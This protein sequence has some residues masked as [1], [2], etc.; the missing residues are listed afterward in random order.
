MKR[1]NLLLFIFIIIFC[2]S[3]FAQEIKDKTKYYVNDIENFNNYSSNGWS[4]LED[5]QLKVIAKAL[6]IKTD[7]AEKI[8]TSTS[9]YNH[10][11]NKKNTAIF[12]NINTGIKSFSKV[13]LFI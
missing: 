13:L 8:I 2:N 11:K 9:Y 5:K 12:L 1:L 4:I 3:L 7:E 6:N 10:P